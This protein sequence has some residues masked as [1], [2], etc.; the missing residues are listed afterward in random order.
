MLKR[1]QRDMELLAMSNWK[2]VY[3]KECVSAR[4]LVMHL[5]SLISFFAFKTTLRVAMQFKWNNR[6]KNYL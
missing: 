3:L 5:I 1:P 6:N 2:V 4:I